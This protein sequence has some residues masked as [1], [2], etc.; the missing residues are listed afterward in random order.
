VPIMSRHRYS[1]WPPAVVFVAVLILVSVGFLY[2]FIATALV[3]ATLAIVIAVW[4]GS[5]P[6]SSPNG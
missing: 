3:A 1:Y 4:V 6:R 5:P 2:P